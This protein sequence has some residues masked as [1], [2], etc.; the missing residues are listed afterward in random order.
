MTINFSGKCAC[1]GLILLS[2]AAAV[3]HET[4]CPRDAYCKA[5]PPHLVHGEH[6]QQKPF[7][8]GHQR[9]VANVVSTS[10]TPD[11]GIAFWPISG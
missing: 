5:L 8:P 11:L 10:V 1:C 6:H 4:V 9:V 3:E 7:S 2:V